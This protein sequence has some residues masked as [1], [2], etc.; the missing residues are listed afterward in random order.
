MNKIF[1]RRGAIRREAQTIATI[2]ARNHYHQ[3]ATL[4][5]YRIK[6]MTLENDSEMKRHSAIHKTQ[7]L[8]FI[9]SPRYIAPESITTTTTVPLKD[10]NNKNLQAI[11]SNQSCKHIR[12]QSIQ[13]SKHNLIVESDDEV[14]NQHISR[15]KTKKL[16]EGE[17]IA[18]EMDKWTTQNAAS[19]EAR[20][21]EN[22]KPE[23]KILADIKIWYHDTF[24]DLTLTQFSNLVHVLKASHVDYEGSTTA[25]YYEMLGIGHLRDKFVEKLFERLE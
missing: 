14:I 18:V 3:N 15:K 10:S 6:D 19:L 8:D 23:S 24:F 2:L 22:L 9:I 5:D 17:S 21:V 16:I 20:R 4:G 11:S 7:G 12:S 1:N 25:K 13:K